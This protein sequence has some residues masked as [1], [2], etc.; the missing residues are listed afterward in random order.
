MKKYF[1][2]INIATKLSVYLLLI[3][4]IP[5]LVV[6]WISYDT[7]RTVIVRQVS[8]NSQELLK[9]QKRYMELMLTSVESLIA[10][11]AS[12]DEVQAAVQA[13]FDQQDTY[14]NLATKA[15]IGYILSG[16]IL[17]LQDLISIDIFAPDGVHFHVGDTL[18]FGEID[19]DLLARFYDDALASGDTVVWNGIEQNVN[20]N[21]THKQVITAARIIKTVDP[22]ALEERAVG[23]LLINYSVD[24][25]YNTFRQVELGSN[26]YM[27]VVDGKNR[28]VYHPDRSQIGGRVS[29]ALLT[30][31]TGSSG[32]LIERIEDKEMFIAYN[33]SPISQWYLISFIPVDSLLTEPLRIRN[34]ALLIVT[35]FL[36][37]VLLL[38]LLLSRG[39]ARPIN[40][41]TE[42]FKRI[43]T[44]S[45]DWNTRL[46]EDRSD[47][48]GELNRWFNIFLTSLIE[49]KET[50]EALVRAKEEA[51]AANNAKGIFLANMSHEI[52]TPMNGIVGMT[53]LALDTELTPQQRDFLT[54]IR[55]SANALLTL[56]NDILD[57]SKI[58]SGKMLFVEEPFRLREFISKIVKSLAV[59]ANEKHLEFLFSI[60]PDVP[61]AIV[62]DPGRLRQVLINLLGNA[63]KFT[64]KGEVILRIRQEAIGNKE[65]L[66]HFTV[67]DTGI[68]IAEN[69]QQLIFEMFSQ[70]D[71][72][73]TRRYG[74]SGLGLAISARLVELMGG[75]IWVESELN[76]GSDFHFTA[77]LGL[78]ANQ[79]DEAYSLPLATPANTTVLIVDDNQSHAEILRAMFQR[80]QITSTIVHNGKEAL[81]ELEKAA[82]SHTP[83]TLVLLDASMPKMNGL[84]IARAIHE[85][86]IAVGAVVM[87]LPAAYIHGSTEHYHEVGIKHTIVKPFHEN[88]LRW[89]LSA[90]LNT[91]VETPSQTAQRIVAEK[92]PSIPS[93]NILLAEDNATNQKVATLLLQR[94]GHRV[95][96]ANNGHEA[97][98]LWQQD[99]FDLILM[100]VQ[101]PGMDG[102]EATAQIRTLERET[103]TPI[104]ALT[105]HAMK[106]DR[107]RCMQAQMDGYLTKPLQLKKLT[108]LLKSVVDRAQEVPI[109]IGEGEDERTFWG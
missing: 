94:Q 81:T 103:R 78:R 104:I 102:F 75:T 108:T 71:I 70:A 27:I 17:N 57:L 109:P 14:S 46:T 89:V 33:Y 13:N 72:S 83:Y 35:I 54:T 93:L 76:V 8:Q 56:I 107:E 66:L 98:A 42:L 65:V 3:G 87:M 29:S 15:K 21:S 36:V 30:R 23:M 95:T 77:R 24:S 97:V 88:N 34:Y 82:R 85:Q 101:M 18:D 47:E 74:G 105:A 1:P 25:F 12:L 86:R 2:R 90:A 48:I 41:I 55:T 5:L 62:G 31:L 26:A 58:E 84:A 106:G 53:E 40:H 6:S 50:E 91:T 45:I 49:K 96:I 43:Q 20:L 59:S 28:L 32:T 10:N 68:G 39:I 4:I 44:G 11:L 92:S 37:F 63:I 73:T 38:A 69:K 51:E 9:Q 64:E 19:E 79:P 22:N 99:H 80:W 16:Y 67:S 61:D 60:E 52:R 100:D 7:S